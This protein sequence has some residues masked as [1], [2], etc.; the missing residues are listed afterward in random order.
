MLI[1]ICLG[2]C[3]TGKLDEFGA[4]AEKKHRIHV[5]ST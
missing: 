4:V 5:S 2:L 3:W 1:S